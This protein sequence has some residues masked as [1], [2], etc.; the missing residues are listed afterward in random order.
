MSTA[1][2]CARVGQWYTRWDKGEIFQVTGYDEGSR[3]IEIQTFD[4]DLDEIDLETWSALPLAFAEQPEDC[5]GAVDNVEHDDLGYSETDMTGEDWAE[6]LRTL[7]TKEEGEE[8]RQDTTAED[9][10]DAEGE[11][12]SVEEPTLD[13]TLAAPRLG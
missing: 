7:R 12:A 3:C 13:K 10:R 8:P 2:G 9:E 4:G 5:T 6:P 11:G 1:V